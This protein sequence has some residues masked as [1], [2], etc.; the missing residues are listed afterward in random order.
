MLLRAK[1][2][3]LNYTKEDLVQARLLARKAIDLDPNSAQ[4]HACYAYFCSIV[5]YSNWALDCDQFRAESFDFARRAIALDVIDTYVRWVLG[6]IYL[7]RREYEEARIHLEKAVEINPNDTEA[8]GVYAIYLVSVGDAESAIRHFDFI[9][10]LNPFDLSWFPWMKGWAFLTL[11]QYDNAV[12]EF[13]KIPEPHN[14]V[15]GLLAASLA[16]LGKSSEAQAVM[17]SFLLMA[18]ADMPVF[19]SRRPNGWEDYW[20]NATCYRQQEDHDH[21]LIGLRSAGLPA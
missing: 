15:R 9:K 10:R 21:L 12:A 20:R 7:T 18:E 6:Y 13:R 17:D 5:V 11:R 3:G 1:A 4:A 14:E 16:Y 19:P 8:R 2:H